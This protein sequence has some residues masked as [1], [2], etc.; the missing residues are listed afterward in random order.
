MLIQNDALR[1]KEKHDAMTE[2]YMCTIH[3]SGGREPY[4]S[5]YGGP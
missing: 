1:L 3:F 2:I 4:V 5:G